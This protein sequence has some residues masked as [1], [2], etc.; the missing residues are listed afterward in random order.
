M[1]RKEEYSKFENAFKGLSHRSKQVLEY[2]YKDGLSYQEIADK[3]N[4]RIGT[5]KHYIN[6]YKDKLISNINNQ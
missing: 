6:R 4:L 3:L 5:I 2:R 1:I